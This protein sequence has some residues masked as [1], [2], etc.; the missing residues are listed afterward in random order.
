M[1]LLRWNKGLLWLTACLCLF[2]VTSGYADSSSWVLKK[3]EAGIQVYQQTTVKAA[4][5]GTLTVD[6]SPDALVAV[7]R[8]VASCPRWVYDCNE[9]R[10]VEVISP[11]ESI[12]YTVIDSPLML[13]DRDMYIHSLTR[14]Q[15]KTHTVSITLTG[16]EYY[17]AEE[18]GR[19]RLLDLRGAWVFQQI[20]PGKTSVSYQ[21]Y[22]NPQVTLGADVVG[23]HMVESVFHSLEGLQKV[24]KEP[25]YRDATFS[26]DDIKA[27]EVK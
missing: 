10:E 18:K 7:L 2:L 6:A 25:K 24:V 1:Q 19:T 13:E 5:K 22:S 8:D 16:R 14:Y 20:S 15:R 21:I 23:G 26:D 3:D 12:I 27:I 11:S 17:A 4:T 9:A